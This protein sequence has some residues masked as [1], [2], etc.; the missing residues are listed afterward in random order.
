VKTIRVDSS[1][2]WLKAVSGAKGLWEVSATVE[3]KNMPSGKMRGCQG[4]RIGD[5]VM[6]CCAILG[7]SGSNVSGSKPSAVKTAGA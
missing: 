2:S 7:T 3:R 4:S 1:E 6:A 5:L